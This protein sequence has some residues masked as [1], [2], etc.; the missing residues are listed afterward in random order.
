[1][2]LL[3]WTGFLCVT[4]VP[5]ASAA[6]GSSQPTRPDAIGSISFD[7]RYDV[8]T[9]RATIACSPSALPHPAT[10]NTDYADVPSAS[11]IASA[12]AHVLEG[13]STASISIASAAGSGA[14]PLT[15]TGGL[16][17]TGDGIFTRSAVI[18]ESPRAGGHTFTVLDALTDT[19]HFFALIATPPGQSNGAQIFMHGTERYEF[20]DGGAAGPVFTTCSVVDTVR[21]QRDSA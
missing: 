20:H 3:R 14:T 5:L 13:D 8:S 19:V 9:S 17:A 18:A 1:M 6:C 21:G 15:L 16:S 11:V 7:G 10:S 12:S 4:L 2:K